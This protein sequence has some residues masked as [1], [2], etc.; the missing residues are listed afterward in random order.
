MKKQ[1]KVMNNNQRIAQMNSGRHVLSK[2]MKLQITKVIQDFNRM[3]KIK[4]KIMRI[5]KKNK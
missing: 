4:F 2:M 5:K 1:K 3:N